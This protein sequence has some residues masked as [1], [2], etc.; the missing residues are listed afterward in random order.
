MF[1]G[2]GGHGLGVVGGVGKGCKS[3]NEICL[4]SESNVFPSS[5]CDVYFGIGEA[6]GVGKIGSGVLGGAGGHGLGCGLG[7][8]WKNMI[9]L[10][11]SK[12]DN[13][14]TAIISK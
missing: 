3:N 2:A 8:N 14:D 1:G 13:I 9:V 11:L 10:I 4:N 6:G 12:I 7:L 5:I